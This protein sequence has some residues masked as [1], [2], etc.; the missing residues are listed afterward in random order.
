M[1]LAVCYTYAKVAFLDLLMLELLVLY[2][3]LN[4]TVVYNTKNYVSNYV[5]IEGEG[6]YFDAF[7]RD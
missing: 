3:C 5:H 6:A 7:L 2:N 1:I 4:A